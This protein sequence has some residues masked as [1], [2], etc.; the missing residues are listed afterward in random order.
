MKGFALRLSYC[1]LCKIT[2]EGDDAEE[3]AMQMVPNP[4]VSKSLA[5][6][7]IPTR[8]I[9]FQ[10]DFTLGAQFAGVA[11]AQAEGIYAARGL[12]IEVLPPCPKNPGGE[13]LSVVAMQASMGM[14]A[15]AVGSTE[16][17]GARPVLLVLPPTCLRSFALNFLLPPP[18]G[19][20][21]CA[22][23]LKPQNRNCMFCILRG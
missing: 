6:F 16:Q 8:R 20:S 12:Q 9:V 15:L 18:F 19:N 11:V 14:S 2:T 3:D 21:K 10:P 7:E 4:V 17:N 5:A 13:V 1:S 23:L 22:G